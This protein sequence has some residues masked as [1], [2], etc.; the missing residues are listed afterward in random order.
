[1]WTPRST[2]TKPRPPGL[3]RAMP[4]SRR[5][6]ATR[7]GSGPRPTTRTLWR[8]R[9]PALDGRKGDQVAVVIEPREDLDAAEPMVEGQQ[10]PPRGVQIHADYLVNGHYH[11]LRHL[12]RGTAQVNSSLDEDS[13]LLAACMGAFGDRVRN[14]TAEVV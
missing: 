1:M 7:R 14:R 2:G 9:L 3:R 5:K 13:G 6:C 4:T 10:L 12:L 8:G 11:H